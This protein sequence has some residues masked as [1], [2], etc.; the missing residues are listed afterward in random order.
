MTETAHALVQR[1]RSRER[2][3]ERALADLILDDRNYVEEVLPKM[4][5]AERLAEE[6]CDERILQP[7]VEQWEMYSTL[8]VVREKYE[9]LE[10]EKDRLE[11]ELKLVIGTA[12]GMERVV[13][14]KPVLGLKFDAEAFSQAHPNLHEEFKR[15]TRSRRFIL[16]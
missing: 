1:E 15:P 3:L 4:A 5:E 13:N 2:K 8:V 16:L 7:S 9:T 10:F 6:E 12:S 14:W 11:A